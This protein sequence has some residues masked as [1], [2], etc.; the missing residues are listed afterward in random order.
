MEIERKF[1]PKYLPDHLEDY[2]YHEIEQGYLC[3]NPT[4]RIRKMDDSYFLTYKG[5][6]MM[7]HEEHEM[8]LTQ[9]AYLHLRKKT[10]GMLITKRRYLIPFQAKDA[11]SAPAPAHTQ[12]P[13]A[14]S[15]TIELDLFR[16]ALDGITL[17]EVEFSSIEEAESFIPPDWFGE[18]VTYDGRYHNSAM[19]R[20]S[21]TGPSEH[22]NT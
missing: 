1:I 20:G 10:D 16:E 15:Y 11:A 18:D 5:S 13:S 19:S 7:A 21:L 6:G 22:E 9:E 17:A 3:T 4:I 8:P 12:V 2:S 14:A